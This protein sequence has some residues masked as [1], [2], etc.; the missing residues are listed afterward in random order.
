MASAKK[1]T[2]AV[3]AAIKPVG[4]R[5]DTKPDTPITANKPTN[6]ITTLISDNN[7]LLL[8][9]LSAY[10]STSGAPPRTSITNYLNIDQ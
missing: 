8:I 4:S 2:P 10:A 6:T 5:E 7:T 3:A 9:D 1:P